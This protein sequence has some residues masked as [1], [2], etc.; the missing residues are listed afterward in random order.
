M[1]TS[2]P[3]QKH[4]RLEEITER[5][6]KR[7]ALSRAIY[8]ERCA[9]MREQGPQRGKLSCSNLAHGFAAS[10]GDDKLSIRQ[11]HSPNVGI[12]TAYNDMLSAHQPFKSFPD[13]I[14]A[15]ANKVGCTAQ[16]AGGTPAMC[17]GVTQGFAGMELSLFSRDAI[18]M[19]TAIALSHNMF[20]A[21]ICL[22]VC[23]KI[24]P[25]LLIG[26]LSFGH[27]PVVFVPAGP[28]SSGL[29]NKEK[30][31]IRQEYAQGKIGREEL[32]AAE[33][34][35]YHSHGTCT[36]YGTANSN[37]MLLEAMGLHI[38]GSAFVHPDDALRQVLT[39]AATARACATTDLGEEYIPLSQVVNE[40]SLVNAIV[41][42]LATGGSTNHTIHWVA[43]AQAAGIIIN[44]DDFNDLSE[45]TPLLSRVYPNGTADVNHFQAAGGPAFVIHTLLEHGLM[46]EDVL[47]VMGSGLN[48]YT[49]EPKLN[50]E[51]LTYSDAPVSES[52]D[53]EVVRP[54]DKP[55]AVEGGLKLLTGN[56][57]RCVIKTSAVA[58]EHQYVE[59][60]AVVFNDQAELE[61]AYKQNKLERDF[62]AVVRFQ[63]PSAN[64]MPEL[65][66]MTPFLGSLQDRGFKVALITDGRMSGA[67]GK[68]PAA[69]HLMPEAS[70]GGAIACIQDGDLIKLDAKNGI[71]EVIDVDISKRQVARDDCK[72][73]KFAYGRE[74][75]AMQRKNVLSAEL[76]ASIFRLPGLNE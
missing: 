12:V 24:V 28:M 34:Q 69:I 46:H 51:Q 60:P 22:G 7:S 9:S 50:G 25:G 27:L 56:L 3:Q 52:G 10:S 36:F 18:A 32:L 74:L 4:A 35:S 43:I 14:K 2:T 66:K 54:V 61:E 76:G 42:L 17:D 63:G 73:N 57:G 75:F 5:I 39:E 19:S 53:E 67:S 41:A 21:A 72:D 45:I 33:S 15:A 58:E 68:V 31:R 70:L 8:L 6:Q 49:Y 23:D 55:F 44:W 47:T 29:P 11:I 71:L 30:A 13:I 20:D 65:H 64:G 62:V 48:K 26:A 38:P 1:S 40:K 37:Q 59:A 16:V